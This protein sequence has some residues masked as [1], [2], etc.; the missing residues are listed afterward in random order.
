VIRFIADAAAPMVLKH[1][2]QLLP[3]LDLALKVEE[4]PG[5]ISTMASKAANKLVCFRH[6]LLTV[7]MTARCV[8]HTAG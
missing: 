6:T 8:G 2:H 5:V 7:W 3:L 4:R 1:R